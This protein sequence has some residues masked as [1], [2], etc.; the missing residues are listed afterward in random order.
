MRR[1]LPCSPSDISPRVLRNYTAYL[2]FF[3][4]ELTAKGIDKVL[5]EYVFSPEANIGT[6]GGPAPEMINRLLDGVFHPMIHLGCGVEFN[7][8]GIV[9]EGKQCFD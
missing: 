4:E 3:E 6:R 8:P 7:M 1:S 9:A 2:K 5:A